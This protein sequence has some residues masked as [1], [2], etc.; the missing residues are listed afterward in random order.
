VLPFFRVENPAGNWNIILTLQKLKP[1]KRELN[2]FLKLRVSTARSLSRLTDAARQASVRYQ[3]HNTLTV[4]MLRDGSVSIAS[5]MSRRR[6]ADCSA[7]LSSAIESK[8]CRERVPLQ[9]QV[10]LSC[11]LHGKFMESDFAPREERLYRFRGRRGR[12]R[13]VCPLFG[14]QALQVIFAAQSI[15]YAVEGFSI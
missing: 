14:A 12:L 15:Q 9:A 11:Q 1:L 13:R 7:W 2:F 8:R 5:M 3:L 10:V 4:G 6:F